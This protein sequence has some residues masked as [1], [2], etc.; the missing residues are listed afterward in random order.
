MLQHQ[1]RANHRT[2]RPVAVAPVGGV[3]SGVA[4]VNN[5]ERAR[6]WSRVHKEESVTSPHVDTPC[7]TWTASRNEDGYGEFHSGGKTVKTHRVSYELKHGPPGASVLHACDN[8]ACVNP[9]H[10]RSGTQADNMLDMRSRGRAHRP[11]GELN[12]RAK[13]SVQAVRELW[14]RWERGESQR[15]I[16]RTLGVSR[17]AVQFVLNGTTWSDIHS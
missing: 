15:A 16:A 8:R 2:P 10:L 3:A 11:R 7:W 12:G 14:E 1:D 17:A 13:L 6:F 5:A 9:D 4:V